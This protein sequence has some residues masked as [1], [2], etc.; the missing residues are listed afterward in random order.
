MARITWYRSI[1]WS[2]R[3]EPISDKPTPHASCLHR[4]CFQEASSLYLGGGFLSH[5]PAA[6]VAFGSPGLRQEGRFLSPSRR[7][8]SRWC[9]GVG[10]KW[11]VDR[12]KHDPLQGTSAC[13][14][15]VED[16]A[17]VGSHCMRAPQMAG[18]TQSTW[19]IDEMFTKLVKSRCWSRSRN[20]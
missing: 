4:W 1:P 17:P 6:A 14:L 11:R 3:T 18:N 15:R 2:T 8:R 7:R 12:N 10:F 9:Q 16:D 19:W 13:I 5:E 20:V